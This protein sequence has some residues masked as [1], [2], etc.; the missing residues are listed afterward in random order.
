MVAAE[1]S[2]AAA[3]EGSAAPGASPFGNL[4]RTIRAVAFYLCSTMIAVPLLCL[5]VLIFP[6]QWIS[7]K[8]RRGGLHMVNV[9]WACL[10]TLLFYRVRVVGRENLPDDSESCVYVANHQSFLDIFSLFHLK[11]NFKFISKTSNFIIPIVGW[12]M[13]LTGH[14]PLKRMDRRSQM[15]CLQRCRELLQNG[16][17]VLFFPEGTRSPDGTMAAFKKGAFSVAQKEKVRVVPVTLVGTGAL[18]PNG[19][20]LTLRPG[21]VDIVVHPPLDAGAAD[22][23]CASAEKVIRSALP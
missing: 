9:L 19:G 20:E 22:E 18:M 2:A 17:S 15:E 12:S 7:D 1:A 16:G 21:T 23:L 6:F 8:Y 4:V 13:F 10:S 3:A 14:V 5:M 11:R